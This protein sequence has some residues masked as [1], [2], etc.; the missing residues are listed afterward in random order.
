MAEF[1][2]PPRQLG[3]KTGKGV[4]G[5]GAR[6][7]KSAEAA[8]KQHQNRVD[9][10]SIAQ[11]SLDRI[12][13]SLKELIDNPGLLEAEKRIYELA[14]NLKGEGASF[15]YPAVSRVADLLCRVTEKPGQHSPRRLKVIRVQIDSLKAMVRENVKGSPR[16]IALEVIQELG[17]LVDKYLAK[18]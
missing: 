3:D 11:E 16:G 2:K 10:K 5:A 4:P 8:V 1:V 13:I 17:V 18:S 12:N 14:H 6:A 7:L 9:Y 15:G